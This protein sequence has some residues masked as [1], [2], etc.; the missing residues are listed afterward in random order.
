MSY[1]PLSPFNFDILPSCPT[2]SS[3]V[4]GKEL[5]YFSYIQRI[6]EGYEE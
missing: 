2:E 1:G 5:S 4:Q 6:T 3:F